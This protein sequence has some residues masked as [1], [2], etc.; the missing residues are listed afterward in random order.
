MG[1][2]DKDISDG[3]KN[4]KIHGVM[5][6]AP[7]YQIENFLQVVSNSQG[8]T[9]DSPTIIHKQGDKTLEDY[10][11]LPE[12]QRVEIIDGVFYDMAAPDLIHQIIAD[13]VRIYFGDFIRKN[14]GK[15]IAVT[16]PADIQLFCDNKTIVQPDVF[17]VCDR[18]KLTRQRVHGAPD[19]IVEVISPGSRRMDTQLK[20]EK[21]KCAGV[22]E[23]WI[24]FPEDRKVLVYLFEK[25]KGKKIGEE[26]IVPI[27]YTFA[28]KVPVGIW[29][30]KCEV[31]FAEIYE[32]CC[33]LYDADAEETE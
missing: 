12:D 9:E 20:L 17:V 23:Y 30:N 32:Q 6:G 27:E 33:F 8:R 19:L 22:R 4:N 1:K 29:G 2:D 28:D 14:D 16:S 3:D 11:A 31:D 10:L 25:A 18:E 21:Y 5:D 13:E 26:N 7:A 24:V 15:C